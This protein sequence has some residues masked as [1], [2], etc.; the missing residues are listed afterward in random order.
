VTKLN[1]RDP[2]SL[3]AKEP[4][5]FIPSVGIDPNDEEYV[6]GRWCYDTPGVIYPDQVSF[7]KNVLFLANY[8][9]E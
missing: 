4:K 7:V 3:A 2:F 5:N 6:A 9:V 1:A 8:S